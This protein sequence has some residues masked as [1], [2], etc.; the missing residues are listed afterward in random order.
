MDFQYLLHCVSVKEKDEIMSAL[1]KQQTD[2]MKMLE[3]NNLNV[4]NKEC[5]VEF[6]PGADMSWQS[7]AANELTRQ[8][9]THPLMQMC[10]REIW[11][12]WVVVLG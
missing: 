8:L 7:W 9:H 10:T 3:G 2:E 12:L 1:W 11:V 6:Q 5:T 4:Y